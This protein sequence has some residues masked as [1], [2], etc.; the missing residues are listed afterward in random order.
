[1]RSAEVGVDGGKTGI[2]IEFITETAALEDLAAHLARQPVIAVDLEADSLH[3]YTEKVCLIQVAT[4]TRTALVDPLVLPG[5]APLAPVL[6]DSAILKVFHGADYDIRSLHRDFGM[7][8]HGLFDTMVACQFLGEKELG[9]GAVLR[10]RFGVELDKRY[11]KADWS[12]RPLT[13]GMVDYAVEDTRLLIGLYRE[14]EAELRQVGRLAWVEEEGELL[15]R[16]R[17]VE[18]GSE[19]FFL[20]FKGA[21]RMSPR[22]LAILEE[23]LVLRD[24][25]ARKADLPPFKVL[26]TEDLA[27]LAEAKPETRLELTERAGL[28]ARLAARYGKEL[29]AAVGR[30]M[31]V[32]G[33][34]LP[35]YPRAPR[36]IRSKNQE[37]LLKRLKKWRE[38]KAR[39]V[40][41]D[42]GLLANNALLEA[43]VEQSG[44][45]EAKEFPLKRWQRDLFST[46]LVALTRP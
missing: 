30:G 9:L 5:L 4:P 2:P 14:L 44:G 23:L 29:V 37:E 33:N 8:V 27:K 34:E 41:I 42:A 7:E 1:M 21:A 26:G 25:L 16:V 24:E 36:P 12:R 32:P 10:K 40:G 43:V 39:A 6:A 31:A 13:A 18:R 20:R 15:S 35:H 38:E 28:A 22:T 19:P 11:Q 45:S 3:H 17:K 46:E